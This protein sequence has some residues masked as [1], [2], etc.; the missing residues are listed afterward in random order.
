MDSRDHSE[1]AETNWKYTHEVTFMTDEKVE[2]ELGQTR[3]GINDLDA[4]RDKNSKISQLIANDDR[5]SKET[6]K[7][8][9]GLQRNERRRLDLID[10]EEILT[11]HFTTRF[12]KYESNI[13]KMQVQ[14]TII[15]KEGL[16]ENDESYGLQTRVM[17]IDELKTEYNRIHDELNQHNS[18]SQRATRRIQAIDEQ[19][20]DR[21]C[22]NK[23]YWMAQKE[24]EQKLVLESERHIATI[25]SKKQHLFEPMNNKLRHMHDKENWN[26]YKKR[27]KDLETAYLTKILEFNSTQI[28]QQIEKERREWHASAE[29]YRKTLEDTK[30]IDRQIETSSQRQKLDLYAQ[31][32]DGVAKLLALMVKSHKYRLKIELLR[33]KLEELRAPNILSMLK[34]SFGFHVT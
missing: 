26:D 32:T 28:E 27:Y 9:E 33:A 22:S 29:V 11:A 25:N 34:E 19:L 31:K 18:N 17:T 4:A 30:N 2:I 7:I 21:N 5:F 16:L 3:A 15:E 6:P 8:L 10:K 20:N 1:V 24:I 13:L 12:K 23:L 14:T